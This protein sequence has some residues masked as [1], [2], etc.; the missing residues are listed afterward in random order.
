M[1]W[2][3]IT[4]VFKTRNGL[5]VERRQRDTITESFGSA[6]TPP[7]AASISSS[8]LSVRFQL[9]TASRQM[10]CHKTDVGGA[11]VIISFYITS[12]AE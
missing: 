8:P 4:N 11:Q 10:T 12:K 5:H 9:T 6:Q 7:C 1:G 2:D 3:G